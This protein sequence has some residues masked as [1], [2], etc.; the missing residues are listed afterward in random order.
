MD[1]RVDPRLRL[2]DVRRRKEHGIHESGDAHV[3]RDRAAHRRAERPLR[4]WGTR[5]RPKEDPD[6]HQVAQDREVAE[7][8]LCLEPAI[9]EATELVRDRDSNRDGGR[10]SGDAKPNAEPG[11]G[12]DSLGSTI[13]V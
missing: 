5:G 3:E 6:R 11:H 10:E 13:R 1:H 2:A 12:A 8:V 4:G 9:D 7:E